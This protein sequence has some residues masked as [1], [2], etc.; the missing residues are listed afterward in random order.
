MFDRHGT[1]IC[2]I[3]TSGERREKYNGILWNFKIL[4]AIIAEYKKF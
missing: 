2:V 4:F 1:T 3:E